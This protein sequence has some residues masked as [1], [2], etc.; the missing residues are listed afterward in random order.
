MAAA[1]CA[2]EGP[3]TLHLLDS[4]SSCAGFAM[5]NE[6]PLVLNLKAGCG[7]GSA[8]S[9]G[10]DSSSPFLAALSDVQLL[11]EAAPDATHLLCIPFGCGGDSDSGA[12]LVGLAGP[13]VEPRCAAAAVCKMLWGRLRCAECAA[14]RAAVSVA[15]LLQ[16]AH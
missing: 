13:R 1:N 11:R 9:I 12:V 5:T 4:I 3:A 6:R 14:V 15:K 7:S 2:V 8:S 10:S 16:C